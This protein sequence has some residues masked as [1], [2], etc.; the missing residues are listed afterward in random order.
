M[1]S[2]VVGL[3]LICVLLVPAS[4]A[5][6]DGDAH[7]DVDVA[8]LAREVRYLSV[9][10][11]QPPIIG[12]AAVVVQGIALPSQTFVIADSVAIARSAS[13]PSPT[14][15]QST[16]IILASSPGAS[17]H[18]YANKTNTASLFFSNS[19]GKSMRAWIE[20]ASYG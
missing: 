14:G 9:Q 8:E 5:A 6:H 16:A 19:S 7:S 20:Q 10:G 3:A 2:A 18:P 17:A 13:V 11:Q 4:A 1:R 12:G 15:P